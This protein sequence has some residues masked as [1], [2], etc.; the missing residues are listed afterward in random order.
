MKVNR[1]EGVYYRHAIA[2]AVLYRESI[3]NAT[4]LHFWFH[5]FDVAPTACRAAVVVH[6]FVNPKWQDRMRRLCALFD[7]ELVTIDPRFA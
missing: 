7:I 3:R 4:P 1:G 6:D 2:Q 5:D